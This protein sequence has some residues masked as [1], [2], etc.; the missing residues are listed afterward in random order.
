MPPLD[1]VVRAKLA[2][3]MIAAAARLKSTT[4]PN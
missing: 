3:M 4:V 2:T 1:P